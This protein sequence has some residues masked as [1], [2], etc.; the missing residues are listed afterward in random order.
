MD[1]HFLWVAPV[2]GGVLTAEQM[3]FML[4]IE[5]AKRSSSFEGEG[6]GGISEGTVAGANVYLTVND[7]VISNIGKIDLGFGLTIA[8]INQFN[9]YEVSN[10]YW[11]LDKFLD[12]YEIHGSNLVAT[13]NYIHDYYSAKVAAP[14]EDLIAGGTSSGWSRVR[15]D[16]YQI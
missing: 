8:Q 5:G 13:R 15:P 1:T 9:E 3:D 12:A 11:Y 16:A 6:Y 2:G 7:V 4:T 10:K 14:Y